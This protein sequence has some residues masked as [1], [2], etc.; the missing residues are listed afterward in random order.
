MQLL[1]VTSNRNKV[2]EVERVLG[3]PIQQVDIELPEIQA[4][5]VQTVIRAKAMSAYEDIGRAVLVEDTGLSIA[6]WN[7]MPG[8]LI[9]WFVKSV[10]NEGICKML[11]GFDCRQATAETWIGYYDG[12]HFGA[13]SGTIAGT[14]AEEPRGTMGF[15]WDP[16]F[17][18]AGSAK[19]FAELTEEEKSTISMRTEAVLKLKAYLDT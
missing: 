11:Q 5:D 6:A 7:G 15:G 17:V 2:Q 10:G 1:F 14:I 13:F 8:A 16:L 19:T 4:I 9:T 3:Y 18:P 12:E